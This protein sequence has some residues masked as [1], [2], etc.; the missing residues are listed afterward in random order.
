MALADNNKTV[1]WEEAQPL[2]VAWAECVYD[3]HVIGI[4]DWYA[5]IQIYDGVSVS[6]GAMMPV[7]ETGTE[8]WAYGI[9][10][11]GILTLT[12]AGKQYWIADADYDDNEKTF[13]ACTYYPAGTFSSNGID[14]CVVDCGSIDV[15]GTATRVL[16]WFEYYN[17]TS[18]QIWFSTDNDALHT[19]DANIGVVWELLDHGQT[20]STFA[21]THFHG[22][23]WC[24][25]LGSNEGTLL[26]FT[27]DW[28]HGCSILACDDIES[29][30]T[31]GDGTW[32]DNW[33]WG[34]QASAYFTVDTETDKVTCGVSLGTADGEAV[35]VRS[36]A[37]I[38]AGLADYTTYYVINKES[39]TVFQLCKTRGGTDAVVIT[40]T[41]TAGDKHL[42]Y[43]TDRAEWAATPVVDGTPKRQ[44]VIGWNDQDWRVVGGAYDAYAQKFYWIPDCPNTGSAPLKCVDLSATTYVVTD[45]VTAASGDMDGH[46]WTGA[47]TENGSL[48]LTSASVLLT[49]GELGDGN[50]DEYMRVYGITADGADV[51][52]L[53]KYRRPD[54][55]LTKGRYPTVAAGVASE[56]SLRRIIV[57]GGKVYF[58]GSRRV[59]MNSETSGLA[60]I[61]QGCAAVGGQFKT[62]R[63][64]WTDG[65]MVTWTTPAAVNVVAPGFENYTETET[66]TT[67]FTVSS[68]YK[69]MDNHWI[70]LAGCGDDYNGTH[71]VHLISAADKTF[72]LDVKY[73]D[74]GTNGTAQDQAAPAGFT[75]PTNYSPAISR[76]C[77]YEQSD[78]SPSTV[79]GYAGKSL[80]YNVAAASDINGKVT[81]FYRT[82]SETEMEHLRG[83]TV[84]AVVWVYFAGPYDETNEAYVRLVASVYR[85]ATAYD[86]G[87]TYAENDEVAYGSYYARRIYRAKRVTIDD[88][89]STSGD[90]WEDVGAQGYRQDNP[91]SRHA[92]SESDNALAVWMPLSVIIDFP[93]DAASSDQSG[94]NCCITIDPCNSTLVTTATTYLADFGIYEGVLTEADM[95]ASVQQQLPREDGRYGRM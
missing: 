14:Q 29:L 24:P 94:Y 32:F 6:R 57:F 72:Y 56:K 7:A 85:E 69:I 23:I 18:R 26:I 40:S 20:M 12:S 87:T 30:L 73:V 58:G 36:T 16:I 38:P 88:T 80:K 82:F 53:T 70:T 41:G 74:A 78:F 42:I 86:S 34:D 61:H 91:I 9:D 64:L 66:D 60:G 37:T 75:L 5:G 68:A 28:D 47:Q 8:A 2:P 76:Y 51:K 83:R 4:D 13:T 55:W 65:D 3:G 27:G 43:R 54:A 71:Q 21:M 17:T 92:A 39:D 48:V 79:L 19:G 84:T 89:P 15:A 59:S 93:L 62:F 22:G 45:I 50:T 63:N 44:H 52:E 35:C 25:N 31:C 46:G 95:W 11:L 1:V 90:D 49:D 33:G 77:S 10:G 81:G 67:K